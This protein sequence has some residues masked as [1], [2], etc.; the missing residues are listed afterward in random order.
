DVASTISTQSGRVAAAAVAYG[1][2]LSNSPNPLSQAAAATQFSVATGATAVGLASSTLEQ[3]LRPDLGS[4]S[5]YTAG[6]IL[7][8]L[9][10]RISPL[11]API[12]NEVIN[13]MRNTPEAEKFKD[14][15]NR[16][17]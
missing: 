9:I 6:S 10:Q 12:S 16:R 3:L 14:L 15:I 17:D 11:A 5:T 7:G 2:V 13:Q 4:M 1:T 8:D